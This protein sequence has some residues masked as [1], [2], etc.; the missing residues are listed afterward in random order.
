MHPEI[1]H[2]FGRGKPVEIKKGGK[3]NE[4]KSE[5]LVDLQHSDN[6]FVVIGSAGGSD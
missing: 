4:H 6:S 5:N 2:H 1:Y 3:I